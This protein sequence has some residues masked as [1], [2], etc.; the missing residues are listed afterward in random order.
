[1]VEIVN[2]GL[3]YSLGN[4]WMF[5]LLL[6]LEDELCGCEAVFFSPFSISVHRGHA[7]LPH[8]G[9]PGGGVA[10]FCSGGGFMDS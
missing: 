8:S 6:Y 4:E 10:K 2:F 1:M 9:P 7:S 3:L 5:V